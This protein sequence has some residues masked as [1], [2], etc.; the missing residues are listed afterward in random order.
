MIVGLILKV[1]FHKFSPLSWLVKA[2]GFLKSLRP[3]VVVI[4]AKAAEDIAEAAKVEATVAAEEWRPRR[5]GS[6]M[7]DRRPTVF[8]RRNRSGRGFLPEVRD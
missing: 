2:F 4:E 7:R 8:G 3:D 6:R 1:L 5:K